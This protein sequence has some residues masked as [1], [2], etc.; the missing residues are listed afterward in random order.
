MNNVRMETPNGFLKPISATRADGRST[1]RSDG[2][3]QAF[4]A[5]HARRGLIHLLTVEQRYATWCLGGRRTGKPAPGT[6]LEAGDEP[7]S[8][9]ARVRPSMGPHRLA[10]ARA[11]HH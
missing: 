11:A 9:V 6:K 1:R 2:R 4:H 7:K 10:A 8:V 5:R 3:R